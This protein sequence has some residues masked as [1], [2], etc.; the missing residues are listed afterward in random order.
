MSFHG[1]ICSSLILQWMC[2]KMR[3]SWGHPFKKITFCTHKKQ[4][5]AR[6]WVL[7]AEKNGLWDEE[8]TSLNDVLILL[9]V[10]KISVV[11]EFFSYFS[12][13]PRY[14]YI[15][16]MCFVKSTKNCSMRWIY[17]DLSL[18]NSAFPLYGSLFLARNML[19]N[20]W[21]LGEWWW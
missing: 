3:S 6:L 15:I 21:L 4:R 2:A 10:G 8:F 1:Q 14:I 11:C 18:Y 5:D 12:S 7:C 19:M 20:I 9:C 13:H 17:M 16:T